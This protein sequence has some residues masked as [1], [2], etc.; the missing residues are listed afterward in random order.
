M[1]FIF[2]KLKVS[3]TCFV[4]FSVSITFAVVQPVSIS[5]TRRCVGT[6]SMSVIVHRPEHMSGHRRPSAGTHH[7]SLEGRIKKGHSFGVY[8]PVHTSLAQTLL[9]TTDTCEAAA[10]ANL[11]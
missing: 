4:Q 9:F 8:S 11:L 6:L 7:Y 10:W 3:T 2:F 5:S 1:N